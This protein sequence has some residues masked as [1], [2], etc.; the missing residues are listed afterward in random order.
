VFCELLPRSSHLIS[1]GLLATIKDIC[2]KGFTQAFLAC[3]ARASV[4]L[5]TTATS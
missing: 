4:V 2:P 3:G 1:C 5:A